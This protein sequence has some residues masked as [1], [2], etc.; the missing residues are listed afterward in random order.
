M[1]YSGQQRQ[2]LK[3]TIE[4]TPCD[5]VVIATPADLRRLLD[6]DKPSVRVTYEIQEVEGN[7]LKQAI[8]VFVGRGK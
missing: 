6:L 4:A 3:E 5:A 2:E 8:E 1:G 7:L